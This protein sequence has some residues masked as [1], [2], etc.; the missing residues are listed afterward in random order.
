MLIFYLM[1]SKRNLKWLKKKVKKLW[2]ELTV[3]FI[4]LIITVFA[5]NSILR[6]NKNSIS[7]DSDMEPQKN[8]PIIEKSHLFVDISGAINK[9][10]VYQV[11]PG[12]RLKDVLKLSGGLSDDA[13]KMFF[14]RN[15]N[16][17]RFVSDQEKIYIPSIIEINT[18]LFTETAKNID[19]ISPNEA[20]NQINTENPTSNKIN[21]NQASAEELDQLSGIGQITVKKIIDNRPFSSLNELLEK[22]IVNKS[23]FEKIKDLI[24]L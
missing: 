21:I 10:G 5:L 3:F 24:E 23:T 13:D 12:A 15:F 4:S 20:P 22:K 18:G 1:L 16:L 17:A 11:P 14:A 19:Y 8:L 2:F 6:N 7:E 9:P